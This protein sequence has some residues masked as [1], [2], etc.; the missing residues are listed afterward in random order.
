MCSTIA[1]QTSIR[2]RT[3]PGNSCKVLVMTRYCFVINL[4]M[5]TR[6]VSAE[7]PSSSSSTTTLL[8]KR[9]DTGHTQMA[10]DSMHSTIER[11]IVRDIF[12]PRDYV[13][14]L[15]TARIRPSPYHVKVHE[16]FLKIN[17]SYFIS[18]RPGKKA[19]DPTVHHLRALQLSS[20]G[21]SSSPSRRALRGKHCHRGYR[22]QMSR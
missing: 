8:L 21:K 20:E 1:R 13:I 9:Y 22:G 16:E 17:G 5:Q 15:Q 14:I 19:G 10:C 2:L 4:I 6:T 11:K 18:L 3:S 12:I 7:I